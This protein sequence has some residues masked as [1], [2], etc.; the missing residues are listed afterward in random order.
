MNPSLKSR[1]WIVLLIAA[2][3]FA[4]M[5]CINED[6]KTASA[7]PVAPGEAPLNKKVDDPATLTTMQ[8]LDSVLNQGSILEGTKME[9]VFR[10]K[11]TGDKPLVIESAQ[12]SCGC[13]VAEKPEEPIMPGQEGRI[14]AVFNSQGRVGANHKTITVHANTKPTPSHIVEFNVAVV[15]KTDGPKAAKAN[16]K[17][18]F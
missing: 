4:W 7:G 3:C 12:A 9:V 1:K 6:S 14:K 5:S 18:Q 11:N 17:Q 16:D 10:F 8:W 13:T 2:S 15:G